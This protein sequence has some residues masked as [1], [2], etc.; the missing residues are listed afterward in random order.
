MDKLIYFDDYTGMYSYQQFK[1]MENPVLPSFNDLHIYV[2][3]INPH[4]DVLSV[5]LIAELVE[6]CTV[7]AEVRVRIPVQA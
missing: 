1:Y 3:I 2:F 4:Y 7:I 5:I 6:H